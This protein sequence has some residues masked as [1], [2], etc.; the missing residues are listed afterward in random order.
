MIVYNTP[1]AVTPE[2]EKLMEFKY[3]ILTRARDIGLTVDAN[4]SLDELF[5]LILNSNNIV[6]VYLAKPAQP[7]E[8]YCAV[9]PDHVHSA[10]WFAYAPCKYC[11]SV[12]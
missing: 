3:N 11:G 7:T 4:M 12:D 8:E 6:H 2:T 1:F 5:S 10:E 9:S